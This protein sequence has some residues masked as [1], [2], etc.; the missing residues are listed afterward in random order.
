MKRS[1]TFL[2]G[3]TCLLAI[4]G[5]AATNAHQV[6]NNKPVYYTSGN[7]V[8]TASVITSCSVNGPGDCPRPGSSGK[9][10]YTRSNQN[11]IC[12]GNIAKISND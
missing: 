6:V 12:S 8:C 9:A 5:V 7:C 2:A 1:K 11:G 10:L 4:A 3:A